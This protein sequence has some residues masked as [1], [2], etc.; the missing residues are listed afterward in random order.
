M[1]NH[2]S[3]THYRDFLLPSSGII[4]LR[5]RATPYLPNPVD[6][7]F[8]PT[9][10]SAAFSLIK[11]SPPPP[12]MLQQSLFGVLGICV[13][14][15]PYR[16]CFLLLPHRCPFWWSPTCEVPPS[17]VCSSLP[18]RTLTWGY[19]LLFQAG[20][21]AGPFPQTRTHISSCSPDISTP[22]SHILLQLSKTKL[23]ELSSLNLLFI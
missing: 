11:H 14:S 9:N 7:M 5:S 15:Y 13:P 6:H 3:S 19:G 20:L 10:P 16:C 23:N 12:A 4:L 8:I 18:C 1:S 2:H 21:G 22:R 17:S